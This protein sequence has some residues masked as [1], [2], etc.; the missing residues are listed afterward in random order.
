MNAVQFPATV[1]VHWPTGP[2]PACGAHAQQ[3][4][5]LGNFL[6]THVVASPIHEPAECENCRNEAGE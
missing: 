6:G 3:L 1:I 5:G 2:V 4:V